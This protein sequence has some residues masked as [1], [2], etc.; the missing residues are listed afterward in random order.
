M[1]ADERFPSSPAHATALPAVAR[2]ALVLVDLQ[3]G[4][5]A[6]SWGRPN[7]HHDS[8]RHCL[9]LH[10]AFA[11]AGLP[12]ILVRHDSPRPESPLRTGQ[13]G[14]DLV[15]GLDPDASALFVTKRVNSAFYGEPDLDAW[16]RGG[17]VTD[18]VIGGIQTNMCVETTA[19]MA[20]NLGYRVTVPIDATHTFDLV[21]PTI[22]GDT[23]SL[24]A[25]E[26][27]RATAVSL[28]GG[29]FAMVTTT[30]EV[31]DRVAGLAG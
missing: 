6:A 22:D 10:E 13:P 20:G 19:R 14:N 1:H 23:W 4:F 16:L 30:A 18:L 17:G 15:A 9:A 21:G 5:E 27:R 7:P 31:L 28:H 12:V 8:V 29:G 11:T 24:T 2:T 26:L 25:D 3:R